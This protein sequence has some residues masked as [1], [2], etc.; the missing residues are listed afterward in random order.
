MIIKNVMQFMLGM[1]YY[2]KTALL[3]SQARPKDS[4][5]IKIFLSVNLLTNLYYISGCVLLISP[6]LI[7]LEDF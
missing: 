1:E 2:L 5:L 4:M 6:S 3:F 7:N